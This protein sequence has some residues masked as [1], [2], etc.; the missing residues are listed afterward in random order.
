MAQLGVHRLRYEYPLEQPWKDIAL[1]DQH[2]VI[3][4][5]GIGAN[6]PHLA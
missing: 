2:Q 6:E 3:E 5:P 1:A 4:R